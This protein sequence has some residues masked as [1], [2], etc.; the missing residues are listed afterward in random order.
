MDSGTERRTLEGRTSSV[1]DLSTYGRPRNLSVPVV[2]RVTREPVTEADGRECMALVREDG[3]ENWGDTSGYRAIVTT[4]SLDD[5]WA[6]F[7]NALPII[8][9][10]RQVAHLTNGDVIVAYP[11]T[12][13]VRTLFRPDSRHNAL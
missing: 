11:K 3:P 10:A 5:S 8:H 9:C 7:D 13:Y 4:R 2:A 6:I 12:G 1:I